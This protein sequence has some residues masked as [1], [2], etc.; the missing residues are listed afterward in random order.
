MPSEEC[1]LLSLS[2]GSVEADIAAKST[3][4]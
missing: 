1:R 4:M 3:I 2:N